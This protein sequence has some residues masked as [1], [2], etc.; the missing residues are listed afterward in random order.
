MKR[1][2]W[3]GMV[4]APLVLAGCSS[5]GYKKADECDRTV[6]APASAPP[7]APQSSIDPLTEQWGIESHGVRLTSAG[8]MLDFRYRVH[9]AQKA[10][11]LL[12]RR[13]KAYVVVEKSDAKLGVPVSAKV[14]ALR[15]STRDVKEER[16][17]FIMFSNPGKHVQP[18][19]RVKIVIGD[20]VT[21][22]LTVM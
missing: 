7:V 13:T 5:T 22:P 21:E 18:G 2:V 9:D 4:A 12:D 15:S 16:N 19:D 10:K 17:Y 20:L 8:Y 11:A 3:I 6:E 1:M 14:G